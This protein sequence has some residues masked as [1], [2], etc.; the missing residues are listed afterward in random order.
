MTG[1]LCFQP[2]TTNDND[3]LILVLAFQNVSDRF[4]LFDSTNIY[5]TLTYTRHCGDKCHGHNGEKKAD[6]VLILREL[7]MG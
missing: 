6:L 4:S 5:Y 7:T 3:I 1:K 2:K